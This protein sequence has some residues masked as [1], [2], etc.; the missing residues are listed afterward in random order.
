MLLKEGE[1]LP[2][3]YADPT[4]SKSSNWILSTSQLTVRP[5]FSSFPSADQIVVLSPPCSLGGDTDLSSTV[6]TDSPTRS[7]T[8]RSGSPSPRQTRLPERPSV[9]IV[10][11]SSCPH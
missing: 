1:Q 11:I 9:R 7:T 6:A 2:A 4:F 3:I 10:P 5:L 8:G